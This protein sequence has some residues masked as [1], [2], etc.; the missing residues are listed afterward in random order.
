[1]RFVIDK[2]SCASEKEWK[3]YLL[4]MGEGTRVGLTQNYQRWGGTSLLRRMAARGEQA[5]ATIV[6][7][8]KERAE[9]RKEDTSATIGLQMDNW[10]Q[11]HNCGGSAEY[12][13]GFWCSTYNLEIVLE[14]PGSAKEIG[15]RAK[16]KE[17]D[18]KKKKRFCEKYS[19]TPDGVWDPSVKHTV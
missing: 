4:S 19:L 8:N 9:T 12:G 16:I 2:T 17:R 13:Y 1:M 15:R 14:S 18:K 10:I 6:F 3:E 5:L 7:I 11:M